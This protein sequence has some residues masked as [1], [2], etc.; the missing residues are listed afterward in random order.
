MAFC[1]EPHDLVLSK[2]VANRERDWEFG[3]DALDAQ[4]V[5]ISILTER[6][7]DLPLDSERVESI[8]KSLEALARAA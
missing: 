8:A 1:L 6:V 7:G 2:L 3:K 4:V 5:E